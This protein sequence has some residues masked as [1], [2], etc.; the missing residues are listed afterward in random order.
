[1]IKLSGCIITLNEGDLIERTIKNLD[2]CDE[3]VVIDGASDDDTV[4]ISKELGARVYVNKWQDDFSL[5][6]NYAIEK[7]KGKWILM[8]D[9][10]EELT[11]QLKERII[12]L[13]RNSREVGYFLPRKNYIDGKVV[14]GDAKYEMQPRLFVA[15]QRYHHKVHEAP[16]GAEEFNKP[17]FSQ[18]EYIRHNKSASDQ[19]KHLKY[20]K[21]LIEDAL[22]NA[23]TKKDQKEIDR[24]NRV[25]SKW[26]AWWK[27]ATR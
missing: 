8:L 12:S 17:K 19:K 6:R 18:E 3:V 27:D 1:M 9:T 7:A 24:L 23:I 16:V 5:Q 25:L 2:F 21:K 26:D 14:D 13:I 22:K 11:D 15:S 20:Q 10:D 4:K